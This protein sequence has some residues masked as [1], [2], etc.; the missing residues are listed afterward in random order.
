MF[1]A[2]TSSRTMVI[3]DSKGQVRRKLVQEGLDPS[4]FDIVEINKGDK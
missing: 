2:K 1:A 3:G 4:R